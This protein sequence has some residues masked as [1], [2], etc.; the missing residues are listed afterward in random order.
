M[1]PVFT[2]VPWCVKNDYRVHGPSWPPV[3]LYPTRPV[4]TV[5]FFDT[6]V[7]GPCTRP[8]NT[9]SVYRALN[10]KHR[11]RAA[12][13]SI[14]TN[15]QYRPTVRPAK[16]DQ[17]QNT[18]SHVCNFYQAM[19]S[20]RQDV[21]QKYCKSACDRRVLHANVE[22]VRSL[23]HVELYTCERIARYCRKYVQFYVR[24]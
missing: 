14:V 2:H 3:G 15:C 1:T 9:D 4:N 17:Q 23:S 19:W 13:N 10:W 5:S 7:H 21:L 16:I 24:T 12:Y 8:V 18:F 6:R 20:S 11:Q 22:R